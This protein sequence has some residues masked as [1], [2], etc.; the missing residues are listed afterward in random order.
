[1]NQAESLYRQAVT[2][3]EQADIARIKKLPLDFKFLYREASRLELEAAMLVP[4]DGYEPLPRI[5]LLRSAAALAYKAGNYPEAEKIIALARSENPD[6][7]EASKLDDIEDAIR[8]A[9]KAPSSNGKTTNSK[10]ANPRLHVTGAMTAADADESAIK[11]RDTESSQV[12]SFIVPAKMFRSVVKS[13]LLE[14]VSAVG[15]TSPKGRLTLE[16]ISPVS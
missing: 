6:G 14:M 11:I 15:K 5:G 8:E 10:P 12:Y 3:A 9:A 7:Y 4:S 2:Y 13:Y 1:M 16:K